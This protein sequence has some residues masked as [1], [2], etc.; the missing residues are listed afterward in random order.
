MYAYKFTLQ[1]A[2]AADMKPAAEGS[3]RRSKKG[4]RR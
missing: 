1:T 3:G 2:Q 4:R